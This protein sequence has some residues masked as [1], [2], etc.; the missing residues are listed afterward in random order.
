MKLKLKMLL[1]TVI[2]VIVLGLVLFFLSTYQISQGIYQQAYHGMNATTL[3]VRDIF[4]TG[5]EG[6]YHLDES[7]EL[8]KGDTIN[9][10]QS[11]DLVDQIKEN[12]GMEVTVFYNDTRYLTTIKNEQ[13]ERQIG[14]QASDKV[15][16]A[17]LKNGKD[18][19]ADNVT[20]LG[21]KYVVYYIPLYQKDSST[22]VG[23]VFLGT[24]QS[25]VDQ[26]VHKAQGVINIVV[27]SIVVLVSLFTTIVISRM[28]KA[29]TSSI[30]AVNKISEGELNLSLNEKYKKR[31][32]EVGDINRSVEALD[33][34]LLTIIGEIKQN[35]DYLAD[36]ST[37]LDDAAKEAA[38]SIEQVDFV[39][40][41]IASGSTHQ[42]QSTE[43][44]AR[45]VNI[46]GG[47]IDETATVIE[48]LNATTDRMKD[49]SH[50]AKQTILA[51]TDS[52]NKVTES[53]DSISEQTNKTNESVIK[54]GEAANLITAIANQTNLLALN[55]S[56]EAARAGEQGK[57]FAVVASEIK[58]LSTQSNESATMIQDIIAQLT[59]NSTEAVVM[60]QEVRD[61][62]DLQKDHLNKTVDVFETVQFGIAETVEGIDSIS[63]K[64][65]ILG[66]SRNKTVR[67]VDNLT[68]IAEENAAGTEEAA[69]SVE[70]VGHLVKEVADH[71]DS[72]NNIA[73]GL[74]SSID[75]FRL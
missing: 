59:D 13:G 37:K 32:D 2:P 55:A 62:I 75:V 51:L 60:M 46:M 17:V 3:A 23:M 22:P 12:T 50:E 9:I 19:Y 63:E 31:K 14:T 52:M 35:S 27:L 67:N 73:E 28:M 18:Y 56:I 66:D 34:K 74:K 39:I 24:K 30:A 48:N 42:A 57:G 10:S 36:S 47:M 49:A 16:E 38:H 43:E 8:W 6:D 11:T 25:D 64:T 20:I 4:E 53:I 5:N 70:E 40:Q 65:V 54:I 58:K 21:D 72:L 7:G 1:L 15:I 26:V 61:T 44:A 71:A 45:D 29:F 41:E 69:A 33:Q 68:A